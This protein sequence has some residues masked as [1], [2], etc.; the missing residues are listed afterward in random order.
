MRPLGPHSKNLSVTD[1]EREEEDV[2]WW[3]REQEAMRE[4]R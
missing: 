3:G 4:G 1:T 2:E